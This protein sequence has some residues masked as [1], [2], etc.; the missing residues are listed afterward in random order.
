MIETHCYFEM[1]SRSVGVDRILEELDGENY[2]FWLFAMFGK[3]T[4]TNKIVF[5]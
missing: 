5:L 1:Q 4:I 2:S 3:M